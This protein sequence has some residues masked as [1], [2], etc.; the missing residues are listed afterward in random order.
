MD[1]AYCP[2]PHTCGSEKG[3]QALCLTS[4]EA[5]MPSIDY[6]VLHA[7][8]EANGISYNELCAAV[9]AAVGGF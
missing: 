4:R 7:F 6:T 9:R 2:T 3:C 8:A 1:N 5:H